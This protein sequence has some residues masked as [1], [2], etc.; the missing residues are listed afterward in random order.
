MAS[1]AEAVEGTVDT[2]KRDGVLMLL[3]RCSKAKDDRDCG[4]GREIILG[5]FRFLKN[6][7]LNVNKSEFK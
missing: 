4:G 1:V 7:R 5:N 2:G 6:Q 3:Y